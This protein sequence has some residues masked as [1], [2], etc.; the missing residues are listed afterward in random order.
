LY[1]EKHKQCSRTPQ[2]RCASASEN[3]A[4]I[5]KG[6]HQHVG[7]QTAEKEALF[8]NGKDLC[9][10]QTCAYQHLGRQG[11]GCGRTTASE[12]NVGRACDGLKGPAGEPSALKTSVKSAAMQDAEIQ[13][14]KAMLSELACNMNNV[15]LEVKAIKSAVLFSQYQ[16]A[17]SAE[18]ARKSG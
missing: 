16:I 9:P 6:P 17:R 2:R 15:M 11:V 3:P 1:D 10:L 8:K 14:M 12:N 5:V 4:S 13:G 7:Q 18:N